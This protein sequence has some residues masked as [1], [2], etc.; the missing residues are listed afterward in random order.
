MGMSR[1]VKWNGL[2]LTKG[3]LLEFLGEIS[4]APENTVISVDKAPFNDHP[5]D[6]G[7]DITLKAELPRERVIQ[8]D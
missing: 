1:T 4:S 3:D 6:P 7:G 8:K 2:T 5:S